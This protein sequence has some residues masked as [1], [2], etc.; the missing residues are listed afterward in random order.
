MADRRLQVFHT[1]AKHLSFTKAAEA[2]C[3]TQPAVTFQVKQLEEQFNARL[4]DRNHGRIRL[5]SAGELV[6]Q[7]AERILKLS[8]ELEQ[9]M[10]EM[11]GDVA[12]PLAIGAS[13]TNGEFILPQVIGEFQKTHPR[14]EMHLTVGNSEL[15]E[16]RVADRSLDLGFIESASHLASLETQAICED[17]LVVICAPKSELARLRRLTPQQLLG[18]PYISREAGSGTREFAD[19]YFRQHGI[20]PEDL[21]VVMELGSTVAIKSVVE[22]G[23]GFSIVSRATIPK[24]LRLGTLLAIALEPKLIRILSWVSLKEQFRTRRLQAFVDYATARMK[25]IALA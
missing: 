2:L 6:D 8:H 25:Q 4:I 10:A 15:I 16:S 3:M 11:S 19:R 22:T 12:G 5:T 9:R 7:Y 13:L 21:N 14:V 17:E 23:L 18:Q 1:V 24:E 20:P